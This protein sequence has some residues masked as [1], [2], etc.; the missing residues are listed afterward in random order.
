MPFIYNTNIKINYY[1][2]LY[3]ITKGSGIV[4]NKIINVAKKLGI[5]DWRFNYMRISNRFKASLNEKKKKYLYLKKIKIKQ[6][7]NS[8]SSNDVIGSLQWL[9]FEFKDFVV[10]QIDVCLIN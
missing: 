1:G 8:E 4:R 9:F 2:G 7:K 10:N 3:F 5:C 6:V